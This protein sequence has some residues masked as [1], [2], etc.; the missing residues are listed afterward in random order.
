MNHAQ[1]RFAELCSWLTPGTTRHRADNVGSAQGLVL[2][3]PRIPGDSL[4]EIAGCA[5]VVAQ[6]GKSES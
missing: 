1:T 5:A 3:Q 4:I 6:P 2:R